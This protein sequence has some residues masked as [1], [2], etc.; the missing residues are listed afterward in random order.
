[1]KNFNKQISP[2]MKK[3]DDT[4]IQDLKFEL[5]ELRSNPLH[6]KNLVD[7]FEEFLK[8]QALLSFYDYHSI[9]ICFAEALINLE[10]E[11]K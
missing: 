8:G 6:N 11:E 7:Y 9:K 1:M 5:C 4:N 3:F 10:I 2:H